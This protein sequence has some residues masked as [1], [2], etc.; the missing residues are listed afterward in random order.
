MTLFAPASEPNV[1]GWTEDDNSPFDASGTSVTYSLA[2]SYDLVAVIPDLSDPNTE[3]FVDLQLNGV[4]TSNYETE[5]QDGSSTTASSFNIN[6]TSQL[7]GII[8]SGRRNWIGADG[9]L[10]AWWR[11]A[12][13]GSTTGMNG[14]LT[15]GSN[16]LS[17][18]TFKAGSSQN[19]RARIYGLEV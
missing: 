12:S 18:I 13:V 7:V 1:P 19:I 2:S 9:Y 14:K 11:P 3:A 5:N 10:H 4:T 16:D 6:D 8:I 15:D 17:Q